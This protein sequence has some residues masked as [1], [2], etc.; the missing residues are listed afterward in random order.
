[1]SGAAVAVVT[2][3]RRDLAETL[4]AIVRLADAAR[5][6]AASFHLVTLGGNQPEGGEQR[7]GAAAIAA[8]GRVLANEMPELAP[9]RI[10][11]C[12]GLPA[13]AAAERLLPDLLGTTDGEA[14]IV[15][16]PNVR[17][18]PRL[19]PGLPAPRLAGPA[20]LVTRE[21]G[22]LATLAWDPQPAPR[23]LAAGE[24]AIRVEA[25]GLNFRDLMWA[26]G[27]L[28]EE[29]LLDG[30]AG[31]TLGM[32]C[33][34]VIEAVGPGVALRPGEA[35]F[36]FAPA[37]LASRVVTRTEAV[38][39]RPATLSSETAATVPVAFLTAVYALE[40]CARLRPGERVLI[41]GGAGAVGLAALQVAL[42]AGARVAATAG[43]EAK[44]AFLC[45]AGAEIALD[46]RDAG[47]ADALRAH[48]PD[49]VDVVLNSLAGEAMER[50]LGLLRPFGRFV[51]LGKRD[52][53]ENRRVALHPL[54]RNATYF[55]VDVDALPRERP[56][57]VASLLGDI[58][59]RLAEGA[60]LPLP[61]VVRG[62]EEVE[63]AFRTLHA[64]ARAL[65]C[66]PA[67]RP[68]APHSRAC[69]RRSAPPTRRS[70]ACCTRRR[71]STTAP[72]ARSTR[73]ASAACSRRS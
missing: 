26:Q 71:C 34:G 72:R 42:A 18:V 60:L 68:T 73:R 24:V 22:Q 62:A 8:L 27:L 19:R 17:L 63:A 51:E 9:R 52:Y 57:L 2:A 38:T 1:M 16:T 40:T 36:G 15:L 48:W 55:A 14:E 4:A 7:P 70:A 64:S 33:A 37:A 44:C 61:H 41:H 31:P 39:P 5:G 20:M 45:A 21:P 65:R 12:P 30:F 66:T 35:V 53:V 54:R 49:G 56:D 43:T 58:R 47:F 10:D 46:S 29:V 23:P 67:T 13:E 59:A 3:G 6:I 28:P 69:W 11:L 32:E 50:S 25:A